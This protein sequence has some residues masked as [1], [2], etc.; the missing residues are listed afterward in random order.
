M[1]SRRAPEAPRTEIPDLPRRRPEDLELGLPEPASGL[2][3]AGFYRDD[4][5]VDCPRHRALAGSIRGAG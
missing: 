3:E 2:V 4:S 1:G 5:E